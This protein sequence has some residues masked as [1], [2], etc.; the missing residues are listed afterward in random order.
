[1]LNKQ[2][3][4]LFWKSR[5]KVKDSRLATHFKHDDA[6]NYDLNFIQNYITSHSCILDLGC[7]TGAIT[8]ALESYVTEISA[9]DKSDDFLKFCIDSP[10]VTKKVADLPNYSDTKQYDLI[11]MFGLL[12]YLDDG[13]VK[14]LYKTCQRLLKENGKL[15]IKHACGIS[16]GVIVDAYSK[17][18]GQHYH[19][20][21]RSLI[22]DRDLLANYF[23]KHSVLDIYS[24]S[25][26]PWLNTH[27]Y[28][29]VV[30]K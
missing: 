2:K 5:A 9:V 23:S 17:V 29:F 20:L 16:K 6:L 26:N 25:L 14:Q 1:M 15:L 22:R 10:K 24:N 4:D 8:N 3:I 19:A 21:Y 27:Y 28:A 12:Y 18:L 13:D 30:E 7:G 11:L